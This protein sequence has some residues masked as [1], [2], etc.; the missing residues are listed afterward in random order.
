M[1]VLSLL[2]CAQIRETRDILGGL[3]EARVAASLLL[4]V[5][6]P[7][8]DVDLPFPE[9]TVATAFLAEAEDADS[10]E[11]APFA[12][13]T[14]AVGDGTSSALLDDNGDGTYT[15]GPEASL[16]YV[17]GA[18]WTLAIDGM[19]DGRSTAE[20][21]LPDAVDPG[22]AFDAVHPIGSPLVLPIDTPDVE[23]VLAFVLD[24]SGEVVW[25]NEPGDI[26]EVFRFLHGPVTAE[27]TL[28]AEAFPT[29]GAYAVGLA[30]LSLADA[31]DLDGLNTALTSVAAGRL[32]VHPLAVGP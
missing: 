9:G 26:E 24:G 29:A 23:R 17:A 10:L 15:L 25:S 8:V 4:D 14:V 7:P 20:V 16:P 30:G 32:E 13:A 2:A 31:G 22:S 3:T 1:L 28:P 11:D 27:L 6:A 19:G 5:P 21:V 18:R 12:G